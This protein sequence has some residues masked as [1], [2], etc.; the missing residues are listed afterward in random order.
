MTRL[1]LLLVVSALLHPPHGCISVCPKKC[2][3][4]KEVLSV[5]CFRVQ[6]VPSGIPTDTRRLNLAYNHIKD[7]KGRDLSSLGGLEE[8]VLSS[9]GVEGLEAGALRAQEGL[10]TLDLQNNKLRQL[11]RGLPPSLEILHLGHNRLQ[12]LGEAALEGL[13]R[14]RLLDLQHNHLSSLRAGV[15]ANL[16]RLETLLLEGNRIETV[17]G[18]LRLPQLNLVSLAHNKI[19]SFPSAFFSQT[20]SLRTLSLQGNL[21]TRVPPG[22]PHSLCLLDLGRNQVR[23][24]RS[25]EMAHLRNLSSLSLSHNRL[26]S[27]DGGLRLPSLVE[28][29]VAGNMLRAIPSRLSPRLERLDCR[30]NL[31]QEVTQQQVSGLKQLKHL[32]LEN[33]TIR[34]FEANALKNSGHLTNLALEQNLLVSIPAGLP[35]SLVRLD[36]KGNRLQTVQEQ[37]L[38]SL[39]RLQV[40]NLRR[41]RLYSLPPATPYLLPRLKSLYLDG[42]PWNCSCVLQSLTRALRDR[43]VE[44]PNEPC[45]QEPI[46]EAGGTT[47]DGAG[48][49]LYMA[50]RHR[51]EGEEP[52]IRDTDY[53]DEVANGQDEQTDSEEYYDYDGM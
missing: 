49:R 13:R 41:N 27:V 20:K 46:K 2:V 18:S 6:A 36:L 3:C 10:R 42:N 1:L 29:E 22:L 52:V 11:P 31:L 50:E 25:R 48:W 14:L 17:Q 35:E 45:S 12:G 19:P 43:G 21:L 32:F 4:D 47:G 39:K 40:L 15:L 37:E 23:A 9:C 5:Q 34:S 8:V 26:G 28:L 24:L 30:Q 16:V 7:L 53:D 51:C 33:N 38:R 44:L